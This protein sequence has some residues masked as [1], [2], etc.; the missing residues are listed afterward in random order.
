MR[1]KLTIAYDGTPYKGWQSQPFG[2]TVQDTME[3]AL[4]RIAKRRVIVHACSRTDTGVHALG[5]CAHIDVDP[6]RSASDWR[7][8]MNFNLPPSIRIVHCSAV[9]ASFDSRNASKGKIYRYTIRNTDTVLP[10]EFDRVWM[11]PGEIDAGLLR[12]TAAMFVGKHDFRGFGANKKNPKQTI[13]TISSLN[14][15][16]RGSRITLT[17]TGPGFLYRMVR[18]ITGSIV[19]VALGKDDIEAIRHRLHDPG[20]PIWRQAAPPGGLCLVRVI[21]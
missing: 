12:T 17:F 9:P 14:V 5:Q 20:N 1:L 10:H 3:E 7:R 8:L 15:A 16:Q 19:R 11:V 13:R 18:M 2:L 4:K 6:G 21:Y